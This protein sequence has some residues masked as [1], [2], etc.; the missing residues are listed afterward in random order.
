MK[1]FTL[2]PMEH[3]IELSVV[4]PCFNEHPH[5]EG[6]LLSW[7]GELRQ[8]QLSFEIIVINDGSLDGSGRVLDKLRRDNPELRVVHQLNSGS[9]RA[10]R[11]GYEMARGRYVLV[12]SANG[13][14]EPTDFAPL[15][16]QRQRYDLVLGRRTH[17]LDGFRNRALSGFLRNL[18]SKLFGVSLEEP[19]IP[20]RLFRRRL[21]IDLLPWV[22]LEW[23]S[24]HF[25]LSIL[26]AIQ[27][28]DR[29]T[30]VKIPYRHRL[31]RKAPSR[32]TGLF[33]LGFSY[34]TESLALK[35]KLLKFRNNLYSLSPAAQSIPS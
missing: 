7:L 9:T 4:L 18:A 3:P 22:P 17:R 26:L 21:T 31:E 34:L 2:N 30:E 5:I 23:V 1:T 12:A 15:W 27:S 11:R 33:S 32:R 20:F 6:I 10:C 19:A 8:K 28:P 24:F 16:E 35:L 29:V 14:C 13:R 25:A